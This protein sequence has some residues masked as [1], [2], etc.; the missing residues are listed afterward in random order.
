MEGF[1]KKFDPRHSFLILE[2]PCDVRIFAVKVIRVFTRKGGIAAE[3]ACSVV[4]VGTQGKAGFVLWRTRVSAGRCTGWLAL[5]HG[6]YR[7]KREENAEGEREGM[8]LLCD[9]LGKRANKKRV[10]QGTAFYIEWKCSG[11]FLNATS[12]NRGWFKFVL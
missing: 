9:G 4:T 2:P 8:H 11:V 6:A 3:Q 7:N 1:T 5:G 12:K 10:A